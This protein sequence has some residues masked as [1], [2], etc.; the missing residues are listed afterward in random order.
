MILYLSIIF[1]AMTLIVLGNIIWNPQPFDYYEVW[2]MVAVAISVVAEFLI[3]GVFAIIIHSL[4]T[5][6]FS[7]EKKIFEVGK[8]ERNFYE[9]LGIKSWKDKVWE[10]G[11]LGGFRKNKIKDPS[12]PEY[13]AQFLYE[14]NMGI[15]MH[16]I[17]IFVGFGVMFI[18]P[19]KYA[20]TIGL[21]VAIVNA[22]LNIMPTMIL[23]Y[24]VP[25]LTV[26][27]KRAVRLKD[28]K[29]TEEAIEN[30]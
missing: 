27:Y 16:V 28:R 13:I 20:L 9:K 3:D 19:L 22:L 5:K 26:A 14:S 11:A 18:L 29:P 21:F 4:P 15:V 1:I 30:N 6:W 25:K 23:R 17:G 2:L 24:N 12:S 8:R 10:L 7:H